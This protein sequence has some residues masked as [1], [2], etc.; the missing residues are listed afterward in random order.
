MK[1]TKNPRAP[2]NVVLPLLSGA[3]DQHLPVSLSLSKTLATTVTSLSMK[4]CRH[5][6]LSHF[7]RVCSRIPLNIQHEFLTID[8]E[9]LFTG[10]DL[11][12]SKGND[13]ERE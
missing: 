6:S 9:F 12:N 7:V 1:K 13:S 5:P 11:S 4:R 8:Y 2:K 3:V 10:L